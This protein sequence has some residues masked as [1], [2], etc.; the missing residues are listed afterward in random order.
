V[1]P[2]CTGVYEKYIKPCPYCGFIPV[3]AARSTP[4]DVDGDLAEMDPVALAALRGEVDAPPKIPYGAR[5]AI[6]GAILKRDREK[7]AA[8]EPLRHAMALWGGA[9]LAEGDDLR[10]AQ[11]RFFREFS[12]D[13]L[14]AQTLG[15]AKALELQQRIEKWT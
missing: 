3:P 7:R 4:D 15:A 12:I 8:Q 14:T 2:E 13:I 1:C 6:L 10:T 11:R 5:G 9:R